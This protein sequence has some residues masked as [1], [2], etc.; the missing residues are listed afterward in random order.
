MNTND[1]HTEQY[2]QNAPGVMRTERC[3][4]GH[5]RQ[6][7]RIFPDAKDALTSKNGTTKKLTQ[8]QASEL[9]AEVE[10][11]DYKG[12]ADIVIEFTDDKKATKLAQKFRRLA[13][14]PSF[15]LNIT[16]KRKNLNEQN[17]Y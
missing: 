4:S 10:K 7:A 5:G 8:K 1:L 6:K 2:I 16:F 14:N 9:M 15:K 12:E 11:G 3:Y 17:K 13:E